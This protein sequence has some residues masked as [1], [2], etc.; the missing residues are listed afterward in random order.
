MHPFDLVPVERRPLLDQYAAELSVLNRGVNLIARSSA[1]RIREDH[2]AHC[3]TLCQRGFPDGCRVVD[4]GSGGGL[5]AIPL[6]ICFPA[7]EF[8]AV[9]S[10][11]KKTD[12]VRIMARRLGLD[13]VVV[14][15]GRA[16]DWREPVYSAVSRATAVLE[17]LWTWTRPWIDVPLEVENRDGLWPRGL[18]CLKGGDLGE[19][20][21]ALQRRFSETK[22]E[23]QALGTRFGRAD[24]DT[25][26]ILTIT[27][28]T[29]S[30]PSP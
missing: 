15:N 12:A 11:A 13:N 20:M 16:E 26:Y 6:A 3:L 24:W 29:P 9:D 27:N 2:I 25:K 4:W 18:I 23:T 14:W 30:R 10:I 22:L 7:V 8:V 1:A 5:P 28:G 21:T 19:E 17:T